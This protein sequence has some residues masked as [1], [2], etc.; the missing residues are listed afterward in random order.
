MASSFVVSKD[1]LPYANPIASTGLRFI[2][3]SILMLP[4]IWRIYVWKKSASFIGTKIIVQ[5]SFISLF[6]VLFFLGLFEALK[7]TSAMRTSVI[8]S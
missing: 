5:Y 6:L 7:T 3:A 4:I 8:Y 2:L 1:L